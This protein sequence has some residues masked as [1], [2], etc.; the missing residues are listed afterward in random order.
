M[1]RVSLQTNFYMT[2]EDQVFIFNV[3]VI[4][5]TWKT[6]STNV[7]NQPV[8]VTTEHSTIVKIRKYGGLHKG[9]HFIPMGMEM[10]DVFRCDMDRFIKKCACLFHDRQSRDNFFAFNFFKQHVNIAF[11]CALA[12]AIERKIVLARDACF[13][14]SITIKSHNSHACD[15]KRDV[16]E[17]VPTTGGTSSLLSLVLVG[18][19]LLAFPCVFQVMVPA[20]RCLLDLLPAFCFPSRL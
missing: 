5:L 11:Q 18:W 16:G 2:R 20:I 10:H 19:S 14:P 8:G 4:N 7:N 15:I 9:H 13:R 3:M 17:I 1:S 12:F 6:M